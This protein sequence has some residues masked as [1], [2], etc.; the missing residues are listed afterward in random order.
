MKRFKILLAILCTLLLLFIVFISLR[1]SLED[2]K[3]EISKNTAYFAD[4]PLPP[5][6]D[7]LCKVEDEKGISFPTK[8]VQYATLTKNNLWKTAKRLETDELK[9]L[10]TLLNDSASYDWGELGTPEINYYFTFYDEN[11]NRVGL[12][13]IDLEGMAYS[14]PMIA[15]MKWGQLKDMEPINEIVFE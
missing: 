9:T 12:T 13:T 15:K 7:S 4:T 10:L 3:K 6:Y 2:I 8:K 5:Q 11:G 1:P 14:Y